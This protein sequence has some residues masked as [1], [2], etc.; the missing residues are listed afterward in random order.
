MITTKNTNETPSS[1]RKK[2]VFLAQFLC[3][4]CYAYKCTLIPDYELE[5]RH[6]GL[7]PQYRA[8][9][10]RHPAERARGFLMHTSG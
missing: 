3:A 9:R 10:I 6:E 2:W 4:P 8:H 7:K 1:L 5:N